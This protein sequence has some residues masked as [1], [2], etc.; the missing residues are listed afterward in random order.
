MAKELTSLEKLRKRQRMK[1]KDSESVK[2]NADKKKKNLY[3]WIALYRANI[4]IFIEHYLGIKLFTFQ[5]ILIHLMDKY[6]YF[7]FIATRGIGKSW[8]TAVYACA[9]CVLYPNQLVVIAAGSKK[10]AALI[11]THK[12]GLELINA[13]PNLRKEIKKINTSAQ[14]TYV[15]FWNGSRIDVIAATDKARGYRANLIIYDEFRLIED[16]VINKIIR[17][18]KNHTR[19]VGFRHKPE[20]AG[21]QDLIEMNK[22]VFLSSAYFKSH[23]MYHR[24]MSYT[25]DMC[26]GDP[27]KAVVGLS[28]ATPIEHG[29]LKQEEIDTVKADETFTDIDFIIEY[30]ALFYG[31][32]ENA[33]FS[34]ED[35]AKNRV[36]QKPVYPTELLDL[37]GVNKKDR[38]K[39][40]NTEIRIMGYDVALMGTKNGK[41][42]N[43]NAVLTNLRCIPEAK[44]FRRQ[45]VD[46]RAYSGLTSTE[47]AKNIK[48]YFYENE[49]DYLVLDC[50]GNG[51][52]VY[53][54]LI[55]VTYDDKTDKEYP[56]WSAFNDDDLKN[57]APRD[58]VPL[59][60]G[61]KATAKSN[62]EMANS[63]R[64]LLQNKRIELLEPM[65]KAIDFLNDV[66]GYDAKDVSI[67]QRL[68]KPFVETEMLGIEMMNLEYELKGGYI[69]VYEHHSAR[70][71]R[72]VSLGMA[73]FLARQLETDHYKK[74]KRTNASDFCK[75]YN[76]MSRFR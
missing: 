48:R 40:S 11:V 43:D 17:P 16:D 29:M 72:Y 47:Q 69:R 24:F 25:E 44:S 65:E 3:N 21:R 30:E 75:V 46:V 53:D 27:Y 64:D 70:K 39:K 45:V 49:M 22:E 18:F 66:Y 76:R 52:A 15:E 37:I 71:D 4:E 6:P 28:Y 38:I 13:S 20:Y 14:E 23:P 9:R 68:A 67:R 36:L 42:N 26:N 73:N 41:D 10:Q 74:G 55:K 59:I 19:N 32:S 51:M 58:A 1:N 50:Q 57:R 5:K 33:F 62:H 35:I 63:L 54:E 2:N 7:M 61:F 60:Y 34:Y 56:A 31:L 8:L 12:I